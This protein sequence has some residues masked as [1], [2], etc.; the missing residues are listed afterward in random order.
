MM[1]DGPSQ[2]SSDL[3]QRLDALVNQTAMKAAPMARAIE[4]PIPAPRNI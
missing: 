2:S 4:R 3:D 1:M